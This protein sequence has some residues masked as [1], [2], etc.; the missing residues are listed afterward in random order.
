MHGSLACSRS[1]KRSA[2]GTC[3]AERRLKVANAIGAAIAEASGSFD[4]IVSYQHRPRADV[5][6][7]ARELAVGEAVRAGAARDAVRIVSVTE[8]PVTYMPGG[9]CRLQ[10][11]AAGPLAPQP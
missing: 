5:V 6:S 10:V 1:D 3:T 7:E 11:K 8:I 2:C 9:S 4:R